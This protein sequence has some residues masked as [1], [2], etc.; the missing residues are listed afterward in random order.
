MNLVCG[1]FDTVRK[2]IWVGD[3]AIFRVPTVF[4]LPAIVDVDILITSILKSLLRGRFEMLLGTSKCLVSY[5]ETKFNK[6]ICCSKEL[7]LCN[8]AMKSVP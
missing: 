1:A 2:A 5:F 4:D 6:F 3:K 8:V 7:G